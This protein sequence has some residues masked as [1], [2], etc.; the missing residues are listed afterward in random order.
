MKKLL[1][2]FVFVSIFF[3]S[4]FATNPSVP[5]N[6]LETE[7]VVVVTENIALF[8]KANYDE[9]RENFEFTTTETISFIQI[10]NSDNELE[11]QLPVMSNKVSIGKSIF[12]QGD[13][14]LGFM[15]KGSQEIQ[16][17]QLSI[18]K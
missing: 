17:T 9:D 8:E 18:S 7:N 10:F 5:V 13:Y 2:V 15:V 14:K 6:L 3:T 16:F 1:S 12:G 11:F 4:A